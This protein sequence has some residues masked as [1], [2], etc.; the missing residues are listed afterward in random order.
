MNDSCLKADMV[1]S[2]MEQAAAVFLREILMSC[3]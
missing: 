1:A 2:R 3:E